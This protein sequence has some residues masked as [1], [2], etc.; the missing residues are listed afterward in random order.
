MHIIHIV[1]NQLL[2]HTM[3]TCTVCLSKPLIALDLLETLP[4]SLHTTYMW[5]VTQNLIFPVNLVLYIVFVYL[6]IIVQ[7]LLL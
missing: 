7:I 2:L 3:T 5:A 1:N 6:Y 4:V